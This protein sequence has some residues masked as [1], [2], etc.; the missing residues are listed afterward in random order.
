MTINKFKDFFK[1]KIFEEL[2]IMQQSGSEIT[3]DELEITFLV[4]GAVGILEEW[5]NDGM[6]QTPAHIASVVH[7]I[8]LK[9]GG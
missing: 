2:S 7:R 6:V 3:C 1:Q 4:S 9:I 8:L 5:I